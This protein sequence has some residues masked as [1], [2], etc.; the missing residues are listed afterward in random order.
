M[1]S[2]KPLQKMLIDKG[3]KKGDLIRRAGISSATMARLNTNKYVSL[4]VIDKICAVLGC[5]PGEI[6]EYV[7]E[8]REQSKV[9]K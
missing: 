1:I 9:L 6:L 2:Y 8:D 3:V 5:Q 7:Q 4:E